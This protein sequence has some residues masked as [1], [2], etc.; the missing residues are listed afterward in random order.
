MR[1]FIPRPVPLLLVTAALLAAAGPAAAARRENVDESVNQ[2]KVFEG[3]A[4]VVAIE[5]P[6]NVTDRDG[7]PVRGLTADSF[8]ILD[9]GE[10]RPITDFEVVD[11]RQVSVA[12]TAPS[13]PELPSAA[14]RHFLL[15]FDISFSD[16]SAIFKARLA[17]RDFVVN[18]L[19]PTDLVA[20]ATYSLETGPRLVITFTPDRAQVAQAIDSLGLHHTAEIDPLRFI[21]TP[22]LE[23]GLDSTAPAGALPDI[24]GETRGAVREA[25]IVIAEQ[26]DR[27]QKNFLRSKIKA[28][29]RS[30]GEMARILGNV[31]GR[32]HVVLFSEGFDSRLLTGTID[33]IPE[34]GGD[35]R[36]QQITRGDLWRVET[37][38][39]YGNTG[40]QRHLRDMV[41]EFRR[42]D[43]VIQAV[44]VGGLRAE[45]G[46]RSDRPI[47]AGHEGLFY[48]ANET[49][50]DLFKDANNLEG[51]LARVLERSEVT[52]VLTFEPQNLR[53]DG[54]FH[55]LRV[56]LKDGA[57]TP[58]GARLSHRQGYY[59]PRPYA[60]LHPL[61][62]DLLAASAIATAQ[63]ASDLDVDVLAAAFRAT[64][65]WAYVPVILEVDGESLLAGQSGEQ[66]TVEIYT[67]VTDSQGEM[68][69]FFTQHVGLDLKT[70]REMLEQKGLKYYGHLEL[71]PG[72]YRIRVLVRNADTGRAAAEAVPISVPVYAEQQPVVLPPFFQDE[73]GSWLLVRERPR[74]GRTDSTVYPFTVKGQPYV[75]SAKPEIERGEEARL[76]L[77]AYNLGAGDISLA[78]TVLG[79]SGE[80]VAGGSLKLVERTVTGIEGYD[81]LL[82]SF[83]A[84]G[85]AAG[86]YTLQVALTDP[87]SGAS[88]LNSIPFSVRH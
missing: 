33:E 29:S 30:L 37:D 39:L 38:D 69:D 6:V 23:T 4:R 72:D 2:E 34:P 79:S 50:G 47:N 51:Q 5:V 66:L 16:P 13:A 24:V 22:L 14:R 54:S 64:E 10:S 60:E 49:G 78:G 19:H 88:R 9:D 46:I 3:Q 1:Y 27:Q 52:Y 36:A 74:G 70:G 28:F 32:K 81:K 63:K 41:Q 11:L 42:A 21:I 82:A 58:R 73:P 43:C 48:M 31:P 20:V 12:P 68:R 7:E 80:P 75:P 65:E 55:R 76:C 77:V 26:M 61:E 71:A 59:E 86:D 67:Y 56:R 87:E 84:A 8:E 85:L 44:D 15:L 62:K 25:L 57:D 17:A 83:E 53:F 35:S 18:E 40:L 45:G